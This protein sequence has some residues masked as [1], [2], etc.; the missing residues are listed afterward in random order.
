MVNLVGRALLV[1]ALG[2]MSFL[3]LT[4][5]RVVMQFMKEKERKERKCSGARVVYITRSS[6]SCIPSRR[7]WR[8]LCSRDDIHNASRG[9]VKS[10]E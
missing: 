2:T 10:A 8:G 5:L 1:L 6:G 4:S 7:E 3:W 9:R